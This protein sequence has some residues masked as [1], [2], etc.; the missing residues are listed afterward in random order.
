M[1][2]IIESYDRRTD[3]DGQNRFTS[4]SALISAAEELLG[5]IWRGFTV[6]PPGGSPDG[7]PCGPPVFFG[8]LIP[9]GP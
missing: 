4:E 3:R 7:K 5:N 1:E 8:K 9:V 2:W 6:E